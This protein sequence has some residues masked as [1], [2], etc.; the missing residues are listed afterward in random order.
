MRFR[1]VLQLSC[2]NIA[3]TKPFFVANLIAIGVG[4]LMIVVMLT[5]AHGVYTYSEQMLNEETSALAIEVSRDPSKTSSPP[6]TES[7]VRMLENIDNVAQVVPLIQGVFAGVK[8]GNKEPLMVSLS[9]ASGGDD[10]ELQR[11]DWLLGS[12]EDFAS[13]RGTIL[14]PANLISDLQFASSEAAIGQQVSL[15]LTRS[16]G[17]KEENKVVK[18]KVA[19]VARKT[20]YGRCY[21]PL[22]QMYDLA[23]WQDRRAVI[24]KGPR[25]YDRVMVYVNDLGD[26]KEVRYVL[27]ELLYSTSSLMDTVNRLKEIAL[28]IY[29]ILGT[30][31]GISLF[32]GSVSIFNATYASTLHRFKEFA[33]YKSFGAT[34]GSIA[35]IVLCD[36]VITS[37]LAGALGYGGGVVVTRAIHRFFLFDMSPELFHAPATLSVFAIGIALCLCLIAG[38][39][40]AL[41]AARVSPA[42]IFRN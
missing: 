22:A 29:V 7:G 6:L 20:R 33:I 10:P 4:V 16:Q 18:V 13:D 38:L 3:R 9:S 11:L 21:I 41:K 40:P 5:I 26:V 28:F 23:A 17:G 31:G 30:I 34:G 1:D 37:L 27:D 15:V 14:L 8:F 39:G 35:L 32:T 36:V 24:K 12:P 42:E 25:E 19:G 2:H